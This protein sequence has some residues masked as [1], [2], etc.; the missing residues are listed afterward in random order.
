MDNQVFY[1]Y[2]DRLRIDEGVLEQGT[3]LRAKLQIIS[4]INSELKKYGEI[5]IH[6]LE[7]LVLALAQPLLEEDSTSPSI[8]ERICYTIYH[9]LYYM[10]YRLVRYDIDILVDFIINS[11]RQFHSL[12]SLFSSADAYYLVAYQLGDINE[13]NFENPYKNVV[14]NESNIEKMAM[15]LSDNL[16]IT[17]LNDLYSIQIISKFLDYIIAHFKEFK[18]K[19]E[20]YDKFINFAIK[21]LD[22]NEV[23]K[24]IE[25]EGHYSSKEGI[26]RATHDIV[27]LNSINVILSLG[28][29]FQE[30][31]LENGD[32]N[33]IQCEQVDEMVKYV[34]DSGSPKLAF[35]LARAISAYTYPNRTDPNASNTYSTKIMGENNAN[36]L[37]GLL[38]NNPTSLNLRDY[39]EFITLY[40]I[41]ENLNSDVISRYN[42]MIISLSNNGVDKYDTF[43]S[44]YNI[45]IVN[46]HNPNVKQEDLSKMTDHVLKIGTLNQIIE[47]IYLFPDM[48]DAD[49]VKITDRIKNS[50]DA[51]SIYTYITC[52][53]KKGVL[54]FSEYDEEWKQKPSILTEEDVSDLIKTLIEAE[55]I[56]I[57]LLNDNDF[58]IIRKLVEDSNDYCN[59]IESEYEV[60]SKKL[61]KLYDKNFDKGNNEIG[62]SDD[63]IYEK[64]NSPRS[65]IL[66]FFRKIK[67]SKKS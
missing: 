11:T 47:H 54:K 50:K 5:D 37:A 18:L 42:D 65:R 9:I 66:G 62:Y 8:Y 55:N 59:T 19:R 32:E 7:E 57:S 34:I 64:N 60:F 52:W 35:K 21:C 10:P 23:S 15:V 27:Q 41:T 4:I 14:I 28:I 31:R 26:Y 3:T 53:Y 29:L 30:K 45:Y 63:S 24:T 20:Y 39:L 2:T 44:I 56:E 67:N 61:H 12:N 1:Q 33:I 17:N 46:R 36:K 43:R 58:Q 25:K 40:S 13:P 38:I 16:D 48:D 6:K 49:K 22:F 51:K